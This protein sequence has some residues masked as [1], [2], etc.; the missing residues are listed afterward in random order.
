MRPDAFRIT[1]SHGGAPLRFFELQTEAPPEDVR[2]ATDAAIQSFRRR[3]LREIEK[4]RREHGAGRQT[5]AA[6]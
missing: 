2:R 5:D 4:A 3:F 6:A 1:F